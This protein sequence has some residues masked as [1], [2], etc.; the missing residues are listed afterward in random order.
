MKVLVFIQDSTV[1]FPRF[2]NQWL[3]SLRVR[4]SFDVPNYFPFKR[5]K[6]SLNN[7]IKTLSVP[8]FEFRSAHH[9]FFPLIQWKIAS[10]N[11]KLWL[12]IYIFAIFK[13]Y[14]HTYVLICMRWCKPLRLVRWNLQTN[15][16]PT[17]SVS[18][19]YRVNLHFFAVYSRY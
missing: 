6:S 9:C 14:V 18:S 16:A 5:T 15:I 11:H 1:L 19:T 4:I 2:N 3:I 12:D 17:F 8:L 10:W 7:N 13:T